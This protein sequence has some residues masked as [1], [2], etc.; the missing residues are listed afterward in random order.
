[1][2]SLEDTRSLSQLQ[3]QN[4]DRGKDQHQEKTNLVHHAELDLSLFN[5]DS[6]QVSKS[7]LNFINFFHKNN[8]RDHQDPSSSNSSLHAHENNEKHRDDHHSR[9]FSCNYCQRKFYSSQALGGHQNAHKRER[10]LAKRGQ[11][12]K[13]D[14][15]D[16][17]FSSSLLFPYRSYSSMASLPLHGSFNR[18]SS[19]G[20]QSHSLIHK[21]PYS[22]Q[23]NR[24]TISLSSSFHGNNKRRL[25]RFLHQPA[26]ENNFQGFSGS[27]PRFETTTENKDEFKKLDLSLR[28]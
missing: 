13:I 24:S 26:I 16:F 27:S 3:E 20:L 18:S 8:S 19:L 1:M 10:T 4:I 9:V 6:D 15:D 2:S 12:M 23:T 25:L 14:S 7:E 17:G 28:L 11:I 5:K 21:P 22:Y